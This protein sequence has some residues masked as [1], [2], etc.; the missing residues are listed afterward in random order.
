[1]HGKMRA[2][3]CAVVAAFAIACTADAATAI[4]MTVTPAGAATATSGGIAFSDGGGLVSVVC[5]LTLDETLGGGPIALAATNQIGVVSRATVG[6][7]RGG[8]ATLLLTTPWAIVINRV[9]GTLPGGMNGLLYDVTGFSVNLAVSILGISVNCLYG[10]SWGWLQA[11]GG[12]NPYTLSATIQALANLIPKVSG[13]ASCPSTL[14][15]NGFFVQ[16]PLQGATLS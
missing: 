6:T 10:G 15:A 4:D 1:M 9:L 3:L 5:P 11:A 8:T 2:A 16:S 14:R 12:T 13:S 7:C